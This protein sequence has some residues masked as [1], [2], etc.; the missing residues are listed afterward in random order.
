MLYGK[1]RLDVRRKFFPE[2]VLVCWNHLSR[3]VVESLCLDVFTKSLDMSL[4]ARV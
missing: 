4:R 2:R 3:E 1:F